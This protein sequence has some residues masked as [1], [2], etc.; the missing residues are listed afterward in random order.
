MK[1]DSSQI[2]PGVISLQTAQQEIA[3][4]WLAFYQSMPK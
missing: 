3:T 1:N 2:T 4:N